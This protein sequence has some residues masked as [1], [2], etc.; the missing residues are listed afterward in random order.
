MTEETRLPNPKEEK[1]KK[2]KEKSKYEANWLFRYG[3]A[4]CLIYLPGI[5]LSVI[6]TFSIKTA[7]AHFGT[8]ISPW[9]GV[10]GFIAWF[11]LYITQGIR[12]VTQQQFL[13]IERFGRCIG[14]RKAGITILCFPNYV[15]R[16]VWNKSGDK[17]EEGNTYEYQSLVLYNNEPGKEIDFADGVTAGIVGNLFLRVL[18][19][20]ELDYLYELEDPIGRAITLFNDAVRQELQRMTLTQALKERSEIWEHIR[21]G[22]QE[23]SWWKEWKELPQ[24]QKYTTFKKKAEYKEQIDLLNDPAE[25]AA[26]W[27][28]KWVELKHREEMDLLMD[29][30][31]QAGLE[32]DPNRG[33]I[34]SDVVLSHSVVKLRELAVEGEQIK[35]RNEQLGEAYAFTARIVAEK[36]GITPQ[37]AA[38]YVLNQELIGALPKTGSNIVLVGNQG[39][40]VQGILTNN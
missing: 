10:V 35:K 31:R 27:D 17:K 29:E 20:K 28:K 33:V 25:Q 40:G 2:K 16:S 26:A 18:P 13:V 8:E 1:K 5:L 4:F 14:V 12:I 7:N 6:C 9:V 22:K 37:E 21:G 38:Q 32:V 39:Q 24:D 30:L 11:S 36:L 19:E 3:L 15:D 23:D 34:I